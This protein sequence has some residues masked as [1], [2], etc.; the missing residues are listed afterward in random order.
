[1]GQRFLT[2]SKAAAYCGLE[3][4]RGLL[5]AEARG[6]V[7]S[8]GRRGTQPPLGKPDR[9]VKMWDIADLDSY[10]TNGRICAP[11]EIAPLN[12]EGRNEIRNENRDLGP[13]QVLHESGQGEPTRRM[14]PQ[15]G[16][17][18]GRRRSATGD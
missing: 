17:I 1:M 12:R 15:V 16:R 13:V 8:A 2:T 18:P 9:R 10:L 14:A 3:T 6:E 5:A 4:A 7:K 11:V